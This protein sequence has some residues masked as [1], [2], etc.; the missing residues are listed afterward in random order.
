MI[1]SQL[2]SQSS[3]SPQGS[4]RKKRGFEGLMLTSLVDAFSILVIFLLLNFSSSESI[5]ILPKGTELPKAVQNEELK[6]NTVVKIDEDKLYVG[7]QQVTKDNL[8]ASLIS[9]RKSMNEAAGG[10]MEDFAVTIQADRRTKYAQLN[11]LV[12]ACAQAGFSDL[13]FAVLAK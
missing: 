6:K 13:H 3:L 4:K 5:I 9:L 1:Q 11:T 12:S 2:G 10:V 7:D 8:L